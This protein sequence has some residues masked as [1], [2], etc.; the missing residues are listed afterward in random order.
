LNGNWTIRAL[1][2]VLVAAVLAGCAAG[3]AAQEVAADGTQYVRY[4]QNGAVSWGILEGETIHQIDDAPYLEHRRTGQSVSR[5]AVTLKAPVDPRSVYMTALNFRSHIRGT[6]PAYPGL[7]MVPATSIIGPEEPILYPADARNV[8]YEA[9]LVV[10][11][12][13]E[14]RNVPVEQARDYVFG[15]TAGNDVTERGWQS[16]DIQWTRGKGNG[17]F[18]A[19]GPVLVKGLD[20]SDLMI[21]GRLNG[22]E[23]QRESSAD[24]LF[25]VDEMVSYI[26]HYFPL[27]PGDLIWSGT[28]NITRAMQPGDVY[29]VEIDGIGILR[30]PVVASD[31]P[32]PTVGENPFAPGAEGS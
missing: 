1:A 16:G 10:V 30:N 14:A 25:S 31:R 28:M 18:N 2:A 7:F 23:R 17:G 19:V 21:V 26:S 29:E 4:E 8:H 5:G 9:E 20:Y 15:V 22:E 6:P 13:R 11:I 32:L 24:M 27:E 12:G 3:E